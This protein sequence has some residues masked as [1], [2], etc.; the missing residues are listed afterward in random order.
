MLRRVIIG[1]AAAAVLLGA[2]IASAPPASNPDG[3]FHLV[4]IW[5]AEGT[6]ETDCV[7]HPVRE[8]NLLVPRAIEKAACFSFQPLETGA[9][10][11]QFYDSPIALLGEVHGSNLSG[12]RPQLYYR[13]MHLFQGR[14]VLASITV[15]RVVN[16]GLALALLLATSLLATSGTRRALHAAWLGTSI[17]VG[18]WLLSTTNTGAWIVAGL[19]TAWANAITAT[20]ASLPRPRRSGAAAL[21]ALGAV[22]ALGSRTE[23]IVPLAAT[24]AAVAV[25]R[26]PGPRTLIA[27]LRPGRAALAAVAAIAIVLVVAALLPETARV[28][29]PLTT[30][31]DGLERLR[32]R[33]AGDPVLHLLL[34]VPSLLV[35]G[36]GVGW[37]LGWID[38]LVPVPVGVLAVT[39]WSLLL[40]AGVRH[41]TTR[42]RLAAVL[43]GGTA[44]LFPL[45][46]QAYYG[47]F[48]SEQFQPRHFLVLLYLVLGFVVLESRTPILVSRAQRAALVIALTTAHAIMLHQQIRRYVTGLRSEIHW[49]LATDLAWWWPGLPVGPTA[50][51]IAGSVAFAVV[52]VV[53]S[54][55]LGTPLPPRAEPR[56]GGAVRPG[57]PDGGRHG[58]SA[59]R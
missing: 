33:G 15:M 22:M 38:V 30:L 57:E 59:A 14:D 27:R 36:L 45:F 6:N 39:A 23:A 2:W 5:C 53:V 51:W 19:G 42:G 47:L 29:A 11:Q 17:P 46:T 21:A 26:A 24:V 43:L 20:D 35:G 48:V 56:A 10:A 49:D 7:P 50:V 52:A 8:E 12:V 25:V 16:A 55:E 18:L 37:G 41:Q 40:V 44:F 31:A 3:R 32:T 34:T 4:N 9:C 13:F 58:R 28:Q 1:T 54:R